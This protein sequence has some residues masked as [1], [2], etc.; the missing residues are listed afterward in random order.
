MKKLFILILTLTLISCSTNK[1]VKNPPFT[2]VK[3]TYQNWFGGREGVQG[4]SIKILLKDLKKEIQF[5]K[6]YF[7]EKELSVTF[8]NSDNV[9]QLSANINTGFKPHSLQMHA[10]PKKEYGNTLQKTTKIF[11]FKL[12][13]NEAVISYFKN[14]KE[15]FYKLTLQKEKDLYMP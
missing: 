14:K 12:N 11:P 8:I 15:Y 10:N 6:I 2:I 3:A 7:K 4:I 1:M 13:K 5:N 9:K